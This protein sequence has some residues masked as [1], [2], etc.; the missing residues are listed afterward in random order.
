[1]IDAVAICGLG[2]KA[3][4]EVELED[5]RKEW[6]EKGCTIMTDGWTDS[7]N[8]TLLNFLV[9]YRGD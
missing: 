9:S 5:H 4:T 6:I 8:K 1:M 7:R 2:F 3:S